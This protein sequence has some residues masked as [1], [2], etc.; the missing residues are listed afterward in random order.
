ME[1]GIAR[2]IMK[3]VRTPAG[4]NDPELFIL[5]PIHWSGEQNWHPGTT[6]PQ[7]RP[8]PCAPPDTPGPETQVFLILMAASDDKTTCYFLA[9]SADN[10]GYPIQQH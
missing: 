1:G 6:R 2:F 3:Q 4:I 9:G 5:N 10:N 8:R 7:E